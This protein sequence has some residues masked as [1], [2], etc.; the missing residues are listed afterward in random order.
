MGL[1]RERLLGIRPAKAPA[2]TALED[3]RARRGGPDSGAS[4]AADAGS[5]AQPTVTRIVMPKD[6]KFGVVVVGSSMAEEYPETVGLWGSRMAY[7]VY[8]HVGLGKSWILQYSLPQA[9]D[10]GTAAR[11]DA[12]WPYDME[13]PG[14]A[15]GDLNGDAII[16]HGFVNTA[17]RFEKL[18][19]VFPVEF[20]AGASSCLAR[21]SSGEFRAA[22]QNGLLTAVEVLLIIPAEAAE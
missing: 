15:P 9:A 19:I 22:M 4:Q 6:G 18:A 13:R 7:T 14:L 3:K 5:D 20:C 2:R 17:G 1:G 10:N 16:V 12:P 8:L 11:I 21:L